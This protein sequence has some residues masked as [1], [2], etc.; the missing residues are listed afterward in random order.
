MIEQLA[1]EIV[2]KHGKAENGLAFVVLIFGKVAWIPNL[3]PAKEVWKGSYAMH[4]SGMLYEC[5]RCSI[6]PENYV[7]VVVSDGLRSGLQQQPHT[8]GFGMMNTGMIA[9]HM[10]EVLKA[11]LAA[12]FDA[13]EGRDAA[14]QLAEMLQERRQPKHYFDSASEVRLCIERFNNC[15]LSMLRH[16]ESPDPR[17]GLGGSLLIIHE[18]I[19]QSL[20]LAVSLLEESAALCEGCV[21]S[22]PEGAASESPFLT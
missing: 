4:K 20:A 19:R 21:K 5:F 18:G 22:P 6:N 1:A 16:I 17:A 14:N 15:A 7:W 13:Q 3:P 9:E 2:D 12:N 11:W 8:F 10:L